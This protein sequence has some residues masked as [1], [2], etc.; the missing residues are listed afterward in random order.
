MEF[1]SRSNVPE[2]IPTDSGDKFRNEYTLTID[3][4]TGEEKL[5]LTGKTNLYEYIQS[6]A[7]DADIYNILNKFANGDI[8]VLSKTAGFYADV[9]NAPKDLQAANNL[10]CKVKSDFEKLPIEVRKEFDFNANKYINSLSTGKFEEVYE[11]YMK[12][13]IAED[14][15]NIDVKTETKGEEING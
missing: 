14:I 11:K 15:A 1:Y 8:N 12:K 10:I 7:E 2:T 3:E 13:S 9:R 5:E 4:E 6:Q